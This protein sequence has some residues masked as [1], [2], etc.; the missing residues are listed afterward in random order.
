V[1][2]AWPAGRR[3]PV[4]VYTGEESRGAGET[5][6]GLDVPPHLLPEGEGTAISGFAMPTLY[7]LA[8]IRHSSY[9]PVPGCAGN[10]S[11]GEF[12][13]YG[14]PAVLR[15]VTGGLEPVA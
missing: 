14:N 8:R 11:Q 6:P 10:A 13:W 2:S 4:S 15:S 12:G 5:T 7:L 9:Y 3:Y 1:R